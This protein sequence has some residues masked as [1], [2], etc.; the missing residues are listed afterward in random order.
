M[1]LAQPS[2]K[3]LPIT[4]TTAATH[5]VEGAF[6]SQIH[7][8]ALTGRKELFDSHWTDCTVSVVLL[9]FFHWFYTKIDKIHCCVKRENT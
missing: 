5:C 6:G 1:G 2:V 4:E 7:L 8:I 9:D 3:D